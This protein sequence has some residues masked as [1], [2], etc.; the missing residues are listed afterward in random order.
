MNEKNWRQYI[1]KGEG[2]HRLC[3]KA[4][5]EQHEFCP[6]GEERLGVRTK[7]TKPRI[8]LHIN[9]KA[10]LIYYDELVPIFNTL[11]DHTLVNRC[12]DGFTQ[13]QNESFNSLIWNYA[14]KHNLYG[15]KMIE[16]ATNLANQI[17]S[18]MTEQLHTMMHW[19]LWRS[20]QITLVA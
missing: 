13:N 15:C 14:P 10:C 6:Q 18:S 7:W 20:N 1:W 11:S 8:H 12:Q 19:L 5:A 3:F 17:S 2:Q 9:R 16:I 4:I